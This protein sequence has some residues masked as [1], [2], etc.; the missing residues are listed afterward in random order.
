[1]S[2]VA[3]ISGV[4][5]DPMVKYDECNEDNEKL[6]LELELSCGTTPLYFAVAFAQNLSSMRVLLEAGANPNQRLTRFYA[7]DDEGEENKIP[8]EPFL[9]SICDELSSQKLLLDGAIPL[10]V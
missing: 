5:M 1:M 8:M 10:L 3:R 9:L 2:E 7:L 6:H 4:D